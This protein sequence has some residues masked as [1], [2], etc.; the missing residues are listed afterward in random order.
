MI[1][2]FTTNTAHVQNSVHDCYSQNKTLYENSV[3]GVQ[4]EGIC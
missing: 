2:P 4:I 3:F 1:H